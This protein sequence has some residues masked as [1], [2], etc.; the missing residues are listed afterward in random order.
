MKFRHFLSRTL[1]AIVV[2]AVIAITFHAAAQNP[3]SGKEPMRRQFGAGAGA[4]VSPG[5]ERVLSVL[6]DEQRASIR[7]ALAADREKVRDLEQKIRESRKVLF[8]L[9]LREKF[10]EAAVREKAAEAAKLDTEMTVLRVKAISKIRPLLTA[11]Q[12]EKIKTSSSPEMGDRQPEP[13]RRHHDIPRD[14]NGLPL[15]EQTP[16]AKNGDQK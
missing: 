11:E 5:F 6:T 9:G 16:P 3:N 13:P 8:E 7:E 14:E 2:T 4:R 10:D 15:K 12:I 1:N